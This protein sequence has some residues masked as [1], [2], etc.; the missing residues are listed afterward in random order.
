[1]DATMIFTTA[2][3]AFFPYT[4]NILMSQFTGRYNVY[5]KVVILRKVLSDY[6]HC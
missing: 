5:S 1:M 6:R 4:E 3:S 2:L